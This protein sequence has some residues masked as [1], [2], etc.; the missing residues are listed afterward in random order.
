[1]LLW[2]FW[3]FGIA[4]IILA[5]E[6]VF[7]EYSVFGPSHFILDALRLP[8]DTLCDRQ[9]KAV[10]T[11]LKAKE[12]WSL[13]FAD[14]W[15]KWPSGVLAGNLYE[16]GN[17]DQCVGLRHDIIEGAYCLLTISLEHILPV[18]TQRIMPGTSK[19]AWTVHLGSCIPTTCSPAYFLKLLNE[20]Y[21]ALPA[22]DMVC[23]SIPPSIGTVQYV[24]IFIFALIGLLM[25]VSTAY[26]TLVRWIRFKPRYNLVIFSLYSNAL[27]LFATT[28]HRDF[29]NETGKPSTI[30]CINGIRVLSMVWVIFSHNY[31]RIGMIPL[32]NSHVI[33]TW[34]RSYHSMLVVASTVSV[35]SFF[36]I[37]GLL[38]CWSMLNELDRNG[39][40]NLPLMYLH[41]YL[42]LTPALAALILYSATL[43]RYSGS[44]PFWDGAMSLTADTCRDYWWSALL[45]VQNY[46]N[47]RE[48]CLGHSWYLSVDMQLYLIAPFLVYPLWRWGRRI[49]LLL[50]ALLLT[51][52]VTVFVLFLMHNL[53][54]SFLA[55][56]SD[57]VRHSY[58]YYPTHTRMGAWL[59]GLAYGYTLQRTR[60]NRVQMSPLA[61]SVGWTAA[62][63]AMLTIILA[64]YPLHQTDY[65]NLP[66]IADATYE[67]LNRV[68]WA[69][70]VGWVIFA[71]VNGY[72]GAVDHFLGAT[73]WQPLGRLSYSI[74]LLHLPIQLM[75]TGAARHSFYFSDLLAAYQFWGDIGFT[76]TLAVFWTL[77]F[78]SPVIGLEKIL[79][80]RA[81]RNS[82]R[83]PSRIAQ[84]TDTITNSRDMAPKP[85]TERCD[86]RKFRNRKLSV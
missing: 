49:L 47:P 72:G 29:G 73:V 67:A 84:S 60:K 21:P 79:F 45:Y 65:K 1:M 43:M 7:G 62:S 64:A 69:A 16:L 31:V 8:N 77:L 61:V 50:G 57:R 6:N 48:M 46:V 39:R 68:A 80:G 56:D 36:L 75:M 9:L 5:N 11:G 24:A 19:G 35:D 10:V 32:V 44:G 78:E 70:A 83:Q 58:T 55:V 13:E 42:R 17:Y 76:L 18:P 27:K 25:F 23:N 63:G 2:W 28:N 51:S 86:F 54:L 82:D 14:A 85:S 12:I 3:L 40:L 22:I 30:K 74:Y 20:T 41:R 26:D 4:H 38:T 37:S 66:I 53:R 33:L 59:V 71:C 15:G 52:M 34:I 81:R